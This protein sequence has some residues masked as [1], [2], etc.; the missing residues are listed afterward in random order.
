MKERGDS[1]EKIAADYLQ[2]KGLRLIT[3]NYHCRFGEIDLIMR[4]QKTL[5]FVEVRLRSHAQFG[6]AAASITHSKQSRLLR[7]AEHYLQQHGEAACRFD[8]ILMDTLHTSS[9]QWIQD[10]FSA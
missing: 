8:A 5:V 2:A 1:A 3:S 4:D 6:G 9:I 7:T 10:A